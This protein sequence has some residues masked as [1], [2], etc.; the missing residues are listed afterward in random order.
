MVAANKKNNYREEGG[1]GGGGHILA[2]GCRVDA[3][4]PQCQKEVHS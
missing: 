4:G 3:C 1:S 2:P